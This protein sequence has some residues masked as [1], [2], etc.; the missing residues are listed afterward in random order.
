MKRYEEDTD[1]GTMGSHR[2]VESQNK[3][4]TKCE[5]MKEGMEGGKKGNKNQLKILQS[6]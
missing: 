5:M 3:T 2:Q 4:K 1:N 6:S